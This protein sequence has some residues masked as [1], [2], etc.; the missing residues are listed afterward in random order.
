MYFLIFGV[1]ILTS[2]FLFGMYVFLLRKNIDLAQIRTIMF[3]G[4]SLDALLFSFSFKSLRRP[5]WRTNIFNN[6][7]FFAAL[8]AS[9]SVL[10]SA[11][12]I[13]VLRDLLKLESLH[14]AALAALLAIGLFNVAAVEIGKWIFIRR[15]QNGA[16]EL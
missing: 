1:G 10:A 9:L 3:V 11:I 5:L 15:S 8:A 7:Y 13:P 2:L 12:Y 16:I 14:P 4:V 6:R